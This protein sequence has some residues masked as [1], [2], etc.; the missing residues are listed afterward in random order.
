MNKKPNQPTPE[1]KDWEKEFKKNFRIDGCFCGHL[2]YIRLLEF[3]RSEKKKS[4]ELG[5]DDGNVVYKKAAKLARTQAKE[6]MKKEIIEWVA[7][8]WEGSGD[9]LINFINKNK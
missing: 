5:C 8:K 7:N 3:I 6:E 2:E 9:D 4:F 1:S